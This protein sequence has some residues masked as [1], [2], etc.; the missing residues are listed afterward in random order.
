MDLSVHALDEAANEQVFTFDVGC[1]ARS[2]EIISVTDT[3]QRGTEHLVEGYTS[4]GRMARMKVT[5]TDQDV[6]RVITIYTRRR[7]RR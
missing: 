7:K 4:D 2:G 5:V 6:L 1:I 3:D